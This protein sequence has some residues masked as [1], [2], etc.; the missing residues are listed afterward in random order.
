MVP[1]ATSPH[2]EGLQHTPLISPRKQW[3]P[4]DYTGR[5]RGAATVLDT[6]AAGIGVPVLHHFTHIIKESAERGHP[7]HD[8][9]AYAHKG[10]SLTVSAQATVVRRPGKDSKATFTVVSRSAR[11]T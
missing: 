2:S 7:R 5:E 1:K 6:R 9:G 4:S 3:H 11:A 10:G 8:Y